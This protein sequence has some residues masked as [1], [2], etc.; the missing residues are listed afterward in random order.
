LDPDPEKGLAEE[1]KYGKWLLWMVAAL[2]FG[3]FVIG[4]AIAISFGTVP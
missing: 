3:G 4:I 2:M 1:R